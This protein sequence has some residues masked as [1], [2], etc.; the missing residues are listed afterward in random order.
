MKGVCG[1]IKQN[2]P[3]AFLGNYI[4]IKNSLVNS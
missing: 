3:I 2:L 1:R 4:P